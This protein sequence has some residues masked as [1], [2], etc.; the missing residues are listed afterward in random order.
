[1]KP[2][3]TIIRPEPGWRASAEAAGALGIAVDGHPMFRVEA[4]EWE[5]PDPSDFDAILA[6]SANVFRHGGPQL[7]QLTSLRVHAVGRTTADAADNAGFPIAGIGS[8]GLQSMI[9]DFQTGSGAGTK[10]L[11]RLCGEER[12]ALSPPD[13]STIEERVLYRTVALPMERGLADR[14]ARGGIVALHSGAAAAHFRDR[15]LEARLDLS[16]I[17]V[18]A[19]GPR[20][21]AMAGPGWQSIHIPETPNDTALLALIAPLCQ[22]ARHAGDGQPQ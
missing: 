16:R 11:L 4:A 13:G 7:K 19:L 12:V 8:G 15:C 2:A 10:R 18:A 14:L 6:G 17:S 20:I 3:L 22:S 21:A 9:D 1:M 5:A